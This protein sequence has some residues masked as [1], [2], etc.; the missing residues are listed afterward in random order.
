MREN[1]AVRSQNGPTSYN[2]L[3]GHA[4]IAEKKMRFCGADNSYPVLVEPRNFQFRFSQVLSRIGTQRFR[5]WNSTRV[6]EGIREKI[7]VEERSGS[8][9]E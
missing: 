5:P 8:A 2:R 4:D 7:S 6:A 1:V 9:R 3:E